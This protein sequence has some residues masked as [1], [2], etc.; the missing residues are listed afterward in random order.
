MLVIVYAFSV[1]YRNVLGIA[2]KIAYASMSLNKSF[3]LHFNVLCMFPFLRRP[4]FPMCAFYR[5]GSGK[6][7]TNVLKILYR[8]MVYEVR[9]STRVYQ[10]VEGER[11]WKWEK[12]YT[13]KNVWLKNDNG[14]NVETALKSINK[15]FWASLRCDMD[16]T[17]T[18]EIWSLL[19]FL[20]CLLVSS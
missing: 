1:D 16:I 9:V 2:R 6:K 20:F 19:W 4:Y 5:L 3:T 15:G 11:K 7:V 8:R 17:W 12:K 14:V 13:N 10:F 18:K